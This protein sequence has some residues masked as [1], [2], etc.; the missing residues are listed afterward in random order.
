M[1]KIGEAMIGGRRRREP[2]DARGGRIFSVAALR[3]AATAALLAGWLAVPS[4]LAQAPSRGAEEAVHYYADWLGY[5]QR[6]LRIPGLQAAVRMGDRE[7]LAASI[8][9]AD[10]ENKVPLENRHLFRIASHSKSFTATAVM[11]LAERGKLRLDDPAATWLPWLKSRPLGKVTVAEL[12]SHSSGVIRDARDADFWQLGIPF[13]DAAALRGELQAAGADVLPA[14]V[15]Y[16]YSNAGYGLLGMIIE[17]AS[18]IPY[19]DYVKR[20]IVDRLGLKHTGPELDGEHPP[21][22][23]VGYTGLAYADRRVPIENVGTGAMSPATGFYANAS[24][25]AS[26]FSTQFPGDGRLLGEDA[27]RRM[28]HPVWTDSADSRGYGLGLIATDRGSRRLVGH[29]GGFP[30]HASMSLVDPKARVAVSVLTNAIDGQA[31]RCARALFGLLDLAGKGDSA[32]NADTLRRFTGRFVRLSTIF[33]V[34]LL[35]GKLYLINPTEED[36]AKTAMALT[37]VDDTTLRLNGGTGGNPYGEPLVYTFSNS[38]AIESVRLG[39]KYVPLD[40]FVLPD[41]VEARF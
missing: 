24:D 22:L 4:A 36:P 34:A 27:K 29:S 17:A 1:R 38:G 13:P 9:Q 3:I 21:G 19:N 35:G 6:Y 5:Q 15:H 39:V 10:V 2:A 23:V 33:D 12:L 20:E 32:A 40:A 37:V 8:G 7:V 18:G 14:N 26:F 28:Q 25:L 16:K 41:R 31:T 11:Q 30:G